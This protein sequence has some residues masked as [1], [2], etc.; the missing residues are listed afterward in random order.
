MQPKIRHMRFARVCFGVVCSMT[1]LDATIRHHLKLHEARYCDT[2]KRVRNSLYV[3]DLSTGHDSIEEAWQLYKEAKSIFRDAAMN[4]RKWETNDTKLAEKIKESEIA[5]MGTLVANSESYVSE[6][7]NPDEKAAVK[8]L[9]IPWDTKSDILNLGVGSLQSYAS[10]M[11]TKRIMLR[12][13]ASIYDP[14]GFL[15]PVL[16]S[17][18]IMFQ[19]VCKESKD[20]DAYID[21]DQQN[22]WDEFLKC[23]KGDQYLR[24]PRYVNAGA[25]LL[26]SAILIGFSDASEKAYSACV[27]MR[28]KNEN[29]VRSSLVVAKTRVAPLKTQTIPRLELL[30]ALILTRLMK[31][32]KEELQRSIQVDR[33]VCCTDAEIVLCWINGI[34][35]QYK[36]FVQNRISEIRENVETESWYHISGIQN[37][38]DLPSRGCTLKWLSD[39]DL[40]EKWLFGPSWLCNEVNVWPIRKDTKTSEYE[41]FETLK[42]TIHAK[43]TQCLLDQEE[44]K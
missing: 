20:W 13:I 12:A 6:T 29:G 14:L 9:G 27:Y 5:D 22:K 39:D 30:G 19:E 8:V 4:L 11:L 26:S 16:V 28:S 17:L 3:D 1:H 24:I 42:N 15:S 31:R 38:A 36:Q 23:F 44:N 18:K 10:V 40:T 33:V 25:G 37:I 21:Q 2:V 41:E 7:L 43:K 32:T 35:K 34:E